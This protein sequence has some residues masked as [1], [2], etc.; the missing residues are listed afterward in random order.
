MQKLT[1]AGFDV[2]AVPGSGMKTFSITTHGANGGTSQAAAQDIADFV[3]GEN[4][5]VVCQRVFGAGG[6][7]DRETGGEPADWPV[8]R[9]LGNGV[10]RG[11]PAICHTHAVSGAPVSRLRLD[12]EVVGALFEEEDIR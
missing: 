9:L 8:T 6:G 12:G 10:G 1:A 11:A 2:I 4:A 3:R 5:A 7:D